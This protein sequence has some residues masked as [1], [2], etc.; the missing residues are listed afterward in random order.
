MVEADGFLPIL[1]FVVLIEIVIVHDKLPICLFIWLGF[2]NFLPQLLEMSVTLD[3]ILNSHTASTM[4]NGVFLKG[5][6]GSRP[7]W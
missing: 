2:F 1:Y 7:L 3:V 4:D 6:E 5:H